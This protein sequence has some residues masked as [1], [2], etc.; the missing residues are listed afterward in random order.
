[1]SDKYEDLRKII[2]EELTHIE[3]NLDDFLGPKL[4]DL[5]NSNSKY[6]FD[7]EKT[8]DNLLN[9]EVNFYKGIT[10]NIAQILVLVS[11]VEKHLELF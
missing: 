6:N 5:L 3:P 8:L 11:S 9:L 2:K 4:D 7:F 1:M 10:L